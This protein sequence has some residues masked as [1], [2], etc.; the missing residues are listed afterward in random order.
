MI[1]PTRN[2]PNSLANLL[3]SIL[4]QTVLPDEVLVVDDSDTSDTSKLVNDM[5]DV[6]LRKEII[7]RYLRGNKDNVSISN[8]RNIGI[9]A[10]SGE[11]MFFMD[12]DVILEKNYIEETLKLYKSYPTAKGVQGYIVNIPYNP[13]DICHFIVNSV[14]KVFFLD[15]FEKNKCTLRRSLCYPYS[16][17][18]IIECEWLH[19]SNMSFRKEVL[20]KFRFDDYSTISGRSI[21][22]D[23]RLTSKIYRYYPH[24]LFM[25]PQSKVFHAQNSRKTNKYPYLTALHIIHTSITAPE[26]MFKGI[27][28]A[29]W[30]LLGCLIVDGGLTLLVSKDARTFFCLVKSYLYAIAHLGTV[31]RG[32]FSFIS[33]MH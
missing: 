29:F 25:N 24:S 32:N 18:G 1:I 31:I 21:G 13:S 22:E 15:Y 10:S 33:S 4:K 30:K 5:K 9:D 23:V 19:G 14:K 16:P 26:L 12:D 27:A 8:A 2:R 28:R 11:I 6:F 20:E 3:F 17:Q 7:L